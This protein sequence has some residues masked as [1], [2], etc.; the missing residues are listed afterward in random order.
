MGEGC[1]HLKEDMCIQMG[2]AAEYY[3][4]T[5]RGREISRDEAFEVIKKAEEN[6]LMHSIPNTDGPGKTHAICNCCGCG[7]FSMRLSNMWSN[8]DMVRSNYV[9][10]VDADK[11]VACGEC[12]ENCPSNALKLG[13]KICTSTPVPKKKRALPYH[14]DWGPENWNPDY[15]INREVVVDTGSSPCKAEC[16]AHIGIQGYI[17]LAS[18]GNY[19]EALE[20]IKKENPFP[21]VC[22]RVC[23][24]YC[25]SACTRGDIDEPVAID[26][27]KKFI[28]EQDLNKEHRYVPELRHVYGKKIAVIGAGP[29]GLSCAYYL[30]IDGYQV[31]VFEK[32]KALGGMLTFGIPSFRLGKD[33]INA[34]IEVLK[35]LGVAFKTSVEVGKDISLNDLRGHGFEAFYIAIGAQLGKNLG[36]VG[37]DAQG[38]TTGVDFLRN[39]ALNQ[40]LKIEGKTIES[41]IKS[42]ILIKNRKTFFEFYSN[43]M[44]IFH[45]K[46]FWSPGIMNGYIFCHCFI[47]FFHKSGHF[48]SIFQAIQIYL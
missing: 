42:F 45:H 10:Q 43:N 27:I 39:V 36:L 35:E 26:D 28:A 19:K 7:C 23:P 16:P 33:V 5:N 3:I 2:H 20:L 46:A 8:P 15:R 9:S 24:R 14:M 12:V 44:S 1:G 18:Q 17:K 37:E 22:G 30:A 47:D 6:G 34:E 25:E 13:Q 21:A 32:Q 40:D 31:S 48:F 41:G 29:A 4:R 11:C 38:V